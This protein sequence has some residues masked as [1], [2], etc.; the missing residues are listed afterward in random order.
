[1]SNPSVTVIGTA[2]SSL[3]GGTL[4]VTSETAVYT[5]EPSGK[6]FNLVRYDF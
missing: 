6:R 2:L 5:V 4:E 3:P 1:M